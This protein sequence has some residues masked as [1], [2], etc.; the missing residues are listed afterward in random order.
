MDGFRAQS[1][2]QGRVS[3]GPAVRTKGRR[4]AK[5]FG[6]GKERGRLHQGFQPKKGG[7]TMRRF[8]GSSLRR[9]CS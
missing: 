6:G 3:P 8:F 9:V 5:V 7:L 2:R 4:R 1:I